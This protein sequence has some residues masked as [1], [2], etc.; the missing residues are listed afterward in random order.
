MSA[1]RCLIRKRQR[2]LRFQ[3]NEVSS[4]DP[5]SI[6]KQVRADV[7]RHRF[8]DHFATLVPVSDIAVI[9]SL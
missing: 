7:D 5:G 9:R 1:G 8:D 4:R 6:A 2:I 3:G